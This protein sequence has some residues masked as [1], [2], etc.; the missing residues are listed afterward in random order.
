MEKVTVFVSML[1]LIM[2]ELVLAIT[3]L[4][5]VKI[6]DN[7]KIDGT[8]DRMAVITFSIVSIISICF[9]YLLFKK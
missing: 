7:F 4:L 9:I 8:F 5:G 6:Y 1:N 3:M 2:L